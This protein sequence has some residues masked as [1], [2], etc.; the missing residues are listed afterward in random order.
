M[1][2]EFYY[3]VE[4]IFIIII[5]RYMRKIEDVSL[6]LYMLI[7]LEFILVYNNL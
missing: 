7:V 6:S 4:V 5:E 2:V 3:V 1:V